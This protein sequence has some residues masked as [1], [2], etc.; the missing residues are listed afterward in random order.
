MQNPPL[1]L[2]ST[3]TF[4]NL[5]IGA[6]ASSIGGGFSR[7]GGN[8]VAVIVGDEDR[9]FSVV[10]MEALGLVHEPDAPPGSGRSWQPVFAADGA[11]PFPIGKGGALAV[12]V[13]IA[14]PNAASV[15][16]SY[17]AVVDIV[18]AGTTAPAALR[19]SI[20]ATVD[21]MGRYKSQRR[22]AHY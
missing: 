11:G 6:G 8:V 2:K 5:N 20:Q 21:L 19:I 12:T 13:N 18:L 1:H 7:I 4:S 15:K 16:P 17:A 14:V 10:R 22:E 9:V 3:I